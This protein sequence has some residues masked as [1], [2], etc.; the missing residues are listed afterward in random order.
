MDPESGL[1]DAGVWDGHWRRTDEG[2]REVEAGG[3]VRWAPRPGQA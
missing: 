1:G 3:G 2:Q